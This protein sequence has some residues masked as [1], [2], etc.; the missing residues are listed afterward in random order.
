[1]IK[2]IRYMKV[3]E[4]GV[5]VADRDDLIGHTVL[6]LSGGENHRV[7]DITAGDSIDGWSGGLC[8]I[9]VYIPGQD[10]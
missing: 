9:R 6:C 4:K 5:I 1:M 10:E 2:E 3:G 7:V 8:P